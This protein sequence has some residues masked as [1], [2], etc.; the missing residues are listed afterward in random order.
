MGNP[1]VADVQSSTTAYSGVS[2]LE[3]ANDL[4]TAIQSGDWASVAMGSVG[5]A[6]D[7]LSMAMDPFGAILAAGVGWLM[8]HVGPL[9][10]ALNALA[11]NPDQI[12]ANSETWANI[13]KE[14][15]SVGEDLV[16]MA[17][18]D[19]S[20]WTGQAGDAYRQRA[21]D[22]S[23][24][25]GSAKE[26][27]EGASS[28]VKTAGEVVAAV[29][30][31]VRDIIAEL[32]GHMISWALQVVFTLGIGLAWVVPEVVAAVAKTASEIANITGKLVKALKALVPLLK[33]AGDLF[34][35]AAKALKN[36]KPGKATP[37]AKPGDLPSGPKGGGTPKGGDGS[38]APSNSTPD[39]TPKPKPDPTPTPTPKPDTTPTPAPKGDSTTPSG[40][41]PDPKPTP[42]PDST[43]P[44][45]LDDSTTPSGAGAGGKGDTSPSADTSPAPKPGG[46]T[47]APPKD[48][49]APPPASR[50]LDGGAT[51]TS[52]A[53]GGGPDSPKIKDN[54]ANPHEN[55]TPVDDRLA[56]GDPIDVATGWMLLSQKDVEIAG[57][58]PL[59]LSR[60]H[61]SSYRSG[62]FFGGSWAST[63]DQRLEVEEDGLHVALADGSLQ[64]YPVPAADGVNVLP[65]AGPARPLR[66]TADGYFVSDPGQDHTL[67]FGENGDGIYPL[68]TIFDGD[69]NRIDVVYG[70]NGVPAELRHSSGARVLVDSA[71]GRITA[72]RVPEGDDTTVVAA[73]H[74]DERGRLVEVIDS[75]GTPTRFSYDVAGRIVRWEDVNGRWYRYGFDSAGRVVAAGGT[76][77]YLD[78]SF[79]Y[80]RENLVTIVT[81]S[82]GAVTRYHLDAR[83]NVIAETDPLGN[84]TSFVYD[85]R[86]RLLTRTDALGR[87]TRYDRDEAGNV[88]AVTA[89]DGTRS[90]TEYNELNRP[91][92]AVG[93][94]G[95]VW[96]YEYDERGKVTG[97]IDP[98]GA[99]TE[100]AYDDAG[101]VARITD[102]LGGTTRIQSDAAGLPLEVVDEDGAV[103][104]YTYDAYGRARTLTDEMGNVTRFAWS[105]A[106]EMTER[107]DPDGARW[108]WRDSALGGTDESVDARGNTTRTEYAHFDLPVADV[109]PEGQRLVYGYDTELRL[110]SVTNE[111]GLVWR[112]TYDAA[113]NLT[114]ETD[115]NGRTLRYTYDA[116]GQLVSRINGAGET[117]VFERDLMGRIVRRQSGDEVATFAYDTAGRLVAARNG[118]AEVTFAYDLLGRTVAET[119]DGRPVRSDYDLLGRRGRRLTPSGA[120]SRFEYG[121][122]GQLTALHTGGRTLNF[123]YD[124]AGRERRRRVG[125]SEVRQIWDRNDRLA[126]QTVVAGTNTTQHREYA[127]LPDGYLASVTDAI[128]GPRTME[129]DS[130]GRVRAVI[131][132]GWQ[133]NYVYNLAGSIVQANAPGSPA[134]GGREYRG[135]LLAAAG[136]LQFGHDA[137]GRT[138]SRQ[139]AGRAWQFQWNADNRLTGAI[140]PTGE[141]WRYRYDALGRRV[142]KQRLGTDGRVLEQTQFAWDGNTLAEQVHSGPG[143]PPVATVWE[144][145][146]ATDRPLTQIEGVLGTADKRFHSIVTDLV[147]TPSELL[148]ESGA[149]EWHLQATLW[150]KV[151]SGPGRAYTP[152]RFPGQ[153]HDAETGL[154]YNLNRYYD[155]ETG[156]YLSHD[157]LGLEPAPDSLAYVGNPTALID[158]L[159]LAPSATPCAAKAK[160][161]AKAPAGGVSKA[162]QQLTGK[163]PIS[164]AT[165]KR[166]AGGSGGGR[167]KPSDGTYGTT[168]QE[169]KRVGDKFKNDINND[170]SWP[171]AG[172][173]IDGNS[174][175]QSEHPIGY[176]AIA[177]DEFKREGAARADLK[178]EGR[179]ATSAEEANMATAKRLED[180]APAYQESHKAHRDN[181]GTGGR[182]EKDGSGWNADSYRKDLNTTL[183]EGRPSDGVQLNQLSYANQ[184]VK[185]D[186]VTPAPERDSFRPTAGTAQGKVA[187]DS[188]HHM[189]DKMEGRPVEYSDGHGGTTHTPPVSRDDV[190][191]M[192]AARDV[193]RDGANVSKEDM[194]AFLHQKEMDHRYDKPTDDDWKQ[195]DHDTKDVDM[196]DKAVQD[197]INEQRQRM[198]DMINQ[199]RNNPNRFDPDPDAMDLS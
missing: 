185:N 38:T 68:E 20:S 89:P 52:G 102:A 161:K 87:Q 186:G 139:A 29:R 14:L 24:L 50:G 115:F 27:S 98:V 157:P 77:G 165:K 130:A 162:K 97:I 133:E 119:V 149:V 86:D 80:D 96:R 67:F 9:K 93:P 195:V 142:A 46:D 23:A 194:P 66:R 114:S 36:I 155:P 103:T 116:A 65:A 88:V 168:K 37:S 8:E 131:A 91:V 5:T 16:S 92:A 42:K 129:V 106:G 58:L 110:V 164:P 152:L 181:I 11:G 19:T 84:T 94:D 28:G 3:S 169:Q 83:L 190:V 180:N 62:R 144:S 156:R 178:K 140:T 4:K 192:H 120:E 153:Y 72:V 150:G 75:A 81:D 18:N 33:K 112:Y 137:E 99:R 125:A 199:Q 79:D 2:L 191:E 90:I 159:G 34:A 172:K 44:P 113:G 25:L 69:G 54:N 146:P 198:Q 147:G 73:Y 177:G 56:C 82:L 166:A 128:S 122:A 12:K 143:T 85:D 121:P 61:I 176:K 64:V 126:A 158:P 163:Q 7:A 170:P 196:S 136:G 21:S 41:T 160:G 15:G 31:L 132:R 71:Q 1:L 55:K 76:D 95:A 193:V 123:E 171:N 105:T 135:T 187:D 47:P 141:R 104:R 43:P 48:T 10:E 51:G 154:H 138:T 175:H 127:Y 124:L 74:Y 148:D 40:S 45:K 60:S 188:Y 63:V 100:Y 30:S 107:V 32:V 117:T 13:A 167:G 70:E 151:V 17:K 184:H 59:V 78:Y 145:E 57:A 49:P 22:L 179:D 53:K 6:L 101:N 118:D 189:V 111:Q 173:K 197:R 35:D 134:V 182:G 174:T 39:P 109:G 183:H 108:R 26:G